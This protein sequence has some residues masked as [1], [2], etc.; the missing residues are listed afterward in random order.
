MNELRSLLELATEEP[1]RLPEVLNSLRASSDVCDLPGLLEREWVSTKKR[2]YIA[3]RV[4]VDV[5]LE[6]PSSTAL[7]MMKFVSDQKIG[8]AIG[9][10]LEAIDAVAVDFRERV[11]EYLLAERPGWKREAA[12]ALT[13]RIPGI[14]WSF[15]QE[16]IAA[17]KSEALRG[18]YVVSGWSGVTRA[19]L[20]E[21]E[22]VLQLLE[23]A[24]EAF[25]DQ[26]WA[27]CAERSALRSLLRELVSANAR[28]LCMPLMRSAVR[29]ICSVTLARGDVEL[30]SILYAGFRSGT[31]RCTQMLRVLLRRMRISLRRLRG[32]S[33]I[34]IS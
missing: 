24:A 9:D 8:G 22:K 21:D 28:F 3:A 17:L 18:D 13:T 5:P 4:V 33:A 27:R 15:P 23:I 7:S 31:A 16:T 10:A 1:R 14:S 6:W 19:S 11:R 26:V 34:E 12:L 2:A 30:G 25:S 29:S 32:P 20:D